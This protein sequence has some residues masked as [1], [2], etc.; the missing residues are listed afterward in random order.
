[1]KNK[2]NKRIVLVGR[3]P[4]PY[5]GI[6][7]HMERL[8][9]LLDLN[10]YKYHIYDI[11]SQ[12]NDEFD[13]V[14]KIKRP[15]VWYIKYLLTSK[16]AVVHLHTTDIRVWLVFSLFLFKP[17]NYITT[18][19]S[20]A[21]PNYLS[22]ANGFVKR[23]STIIINHTDL[24]ITVNEEFR[25]ILLYSL[26]P[27]GLIPEKIKTIHAFLPP[28]ITDDDVKKI[29]TSV[30]N[31]ISS[32]EPIISANAYSLSFHNGYDLY[33]IDMCIE[34]C[35]SLKKEYPKIGFVICISVVNSITAEYYEK[36]K[37]KISEFDLNSNI[38][39]CTNGVSFPPILLKSDVFVRPTNTDGDALSIREALALGIPAIA[40]DIV[41]RPDECV[42]F[43]TRDKNDFRH[44]VIEV[45]ESECNRS[46]RLTI[47]SPEQMNEIMKIYERYI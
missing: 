26:K 4:L 36:L 41:K 33:G 29:P 31:F 34:L 42:V 35:L 8:A 43:K 44:K 7:V 17:S 21:I 13:Q 37:D 23:I 39:L 10:G 14:S 25:S 22:K 24:F 12:E 15:Y 40:S 47:S 30:E 9:K 6:S 38:L 1:M 18:I 3:Y 5:G 2:L 45:L 16:D 11:F 28:I 46:N 32:H 19:H 27:Y 20:V